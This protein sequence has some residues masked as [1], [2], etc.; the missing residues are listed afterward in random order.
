MNRAGINRIIIFVVVALLFGAVAYLV[1]T[2]PSENYRL[3]SN[4]KIDLNHGWT[5]EHDGILINDVNFPYDLKLKE[6][7]KYIARL[8][9]PDGLGNNSSLRIR[10]SMQDVIVYVDGIEIF[11]DIK[12][13]DGKIKVPDASL[14]HL[15]E[16]PDSI[17]GR[18]L[19]IEMSS[20]TIA[21]SGMLNEVYA[22]QEK[23]LIF[24][25]IISNIFKIILSLIFFVFGLIT[26]VLSGVVKKLEDNRLI[27]L[28][29]F[30]VFVAIWIFSE[31][32]VMQLFIG[33]RFIIGSLSYIVIPLI[34]TSF[35]LFLRASV[36]KKYKSIM[37]TLAILFIIDLILNLYLQLAGILTFISSMNITVVLIVLAMAA[38][39]FFMVIEWIK[40]GN[41]QAK[42]MLIYS[43]TLGVFLLIEVI[44]FFLGIYEIIGYFTGVGIILFFLQ[45]S[46]NTFNF[47]NNMIQ[48]EKESEILKKLAYKDVLT[49]MGNR[50][51]FEKYIDGLRRSNS[52]KSFKLAMMDIN[53]LKYIN[54]NYGHKVGDEAI[55]ACA[56]VIDTYL[57]PHGDCFRLGG[58]EF[59]CVIFDLDAEVYKGLVNK[60]REELNATK[61]DHEY[62]LD[63]AIG[64]DTF[65]YNKGINIS[66]FIHETDMKMYSNKK[67]IKNRE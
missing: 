56:E 19:R 36:L 53:N 38:S 64:S 2:L 30:A 43:S 16:L 35:A 51:A 50:A 3:I 41:Q 10:S 67:K 26:I 62:I 42:Q 40:H 29:T 65:D 27:Y 7:T 23:D 21:F 60:M 24:D 55:R 49:N 13:K 57:K 8:I 48:N 4:K 54:D 61:S 12:A 15:F 44:V 39:L 1:L 14:W 37:V 66:D 45:I 9:L 11:R 6:N 17:S 33:N 47:I 52:K 59:A 20:P 22:G 58:D 5:V 34:T 46:F 31:S 18:E 63:I 25:I 32:K 28:G